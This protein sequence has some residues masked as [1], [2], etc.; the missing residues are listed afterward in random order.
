MT[1][2]IEEVPEDLMTPAQVAEWAAFCE[3]DEAYSMNCQAYSE[4]VAEGF[5]SFY[6]NCSDPYLTTGDVER[7][8]GLTRPVAPVA[9][10]W[11]PAWDG[12]PE[13]AATIKAILA[14][15]ED[16]CPF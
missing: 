11:R 1:T 12:A 15:M 3:A 5:A 10:T 9:P 7:E 2:K 4:I 14:G 16:D 8:L 6:G 13:P